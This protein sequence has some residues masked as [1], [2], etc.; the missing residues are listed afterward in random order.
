MAPPRAREKVTYTPRRGALGA[1]VDT[2]KLSDREYEIAVANGLIK[3][4]T[5]WYSTFLS[6][7]CYLEES[8]IFRASAPTD[9]RKSRR[10]EIL[11]LKRKLK[12]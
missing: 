12:I 11:D 3:G 5:R 9:T 1:F 8:C 6:S 7:R 2:T 4:R 10:E